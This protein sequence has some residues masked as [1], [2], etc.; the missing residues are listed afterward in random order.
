MCCTHP[1]ALLK[2][3]K[4]YTLQQTDSYSNCKITML[5]S[6]PDWIKLICPPLL[7]K[8]SDEATPVER[9]PSRTSTD[10]YF[11]YIYNGLSDKKNMF[12]HGRVRTI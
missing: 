4:G 5:S 10:S 9:T 7:S 12:K 1:N 3:S 8:K 11:I 6:I 2:V